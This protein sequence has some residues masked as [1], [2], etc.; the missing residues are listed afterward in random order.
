MSSIVLLSRVGGHG[1]EMPMYRKMYMSA[2][3]S[4]MRFDMLLLLCLHCR[5][6][7]SSVVRLRRRRWLNAGWNKGWIVAGFFDTCQ[8]S[9]VVVHMG[10]YIL[11]AHFWMPLSKVTCRLSNSGLRA[12]LKSPTVAW[13]V[14]DPN[15]DT[16]V[17][18]N[19]Y[20]R[21]RSAPFMSIKCP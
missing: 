17:G 20:P 10:N 8:E 4:E 19:Q 2:F 3:L 13:L 1:P 21:K 7:D 15:Y 16:M 5:L 18:S 6:N 9:I 11:H 12:L 14:L